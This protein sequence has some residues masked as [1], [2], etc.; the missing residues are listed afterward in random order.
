MKN[1]IK[2]FSMAISILLFLSVMA[3]GA[4]ASA[5]EG[6]A[7]P[8]LYMTVKPDSRIEPGSDITILLWTDPVKTLAG[9]TTQLTLWKQLPEEDVPGF[10]PSGW[11]GLGGWATKPVTLGAEGQHVEIIEGGL[12]RGVYSFSAV[13]STTA[14]PEE[15]SITIF[16]SVH[17]GDPL[18][19]VDSLSLYPE[20][21][22]SSLSDWNKYAL[23]DT[24]EYSVLATQSAPDPQDFS[25]SIRVEV[26]NDDTTPLY[27]ETFAITPGNTE[28]F[29]S[30]DTTNWDEGMYYFSAEVEAADGAT[31][32]HEQEFHLANVIVTDIDLAQP[33]VRGVMMEASG[34]TFTATEMTLSVFDPVAT[35]VLV[36]SQTLPVVDGMASLPFDTSA[37]EVSPDGFIEVKA[38]GGVTVDS[39]G[40]SDT[41]TEQFPDFIVGVELSNFG[42]MVSGDSFQ[43]NVTTM[44]PQPGATGSLTIRRGGQP[45]I[46][47]ASVGL[48]SS[49]KD[50]VNV[51]GADTASWENGTYTVKVAITGDLSEKTGSA[52][53]FVGTGLQLMAEPSRATYTGYDPLVLT[54]ELTPSRSGT[55]MLV[56]ASDDLFFN[57]FLLVQ[58]TDVD[59][60]SRV[61]HVPITSPADA[62]WSWSVS[63]ETE[64]GSESAFAFGS[65]PYTVG[66]Q[67]TDGDWLPDPVE[68]AEGSDVNDFDTDGDQQY[69]GIEVYYD[70]DPTDP[71]SMIPEFSTILVFAAIP[72][73]SLILLLYK[74]RLPP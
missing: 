52:F 8:T 35:G 56:L 41:A 60:S 40:Y 37:F 69:D 21:G 9:E 55:Q 70:F 10:P 17:V 50:V 71:G 7:L 46:F 25:G 27:D 68:E 5:Q 13:V 48:D 31:A 38:E 44:L 24:I 1:Q 36:E 64:D 18:P 11:G 47:Q 32:V 14:S 45:W 34:V 4:P 19:R 20:S 49:G 42:F 15:A 72:A 65:A 67:D 33:A 58:Y 29:G 12:S 30:F 61:I 73:V 53:L 39:M 3:F 63:V 23:G 74:K 62:E 66:S 26:N 43:I 51:E 16:K 59:F 22:Y 57:T 54:L 28:V 2:I 6:P